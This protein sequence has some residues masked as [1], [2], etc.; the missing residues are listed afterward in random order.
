VRLF[1]ENYAADGVRLPD[2]A[3]DRLR[4]AAQR[5][6][7][8]GLC[9]L[10]CARVG[11]APPLDPMDAVVAAARLA[12]DV[13]RLALPID[14]PAPCAACGACDRVC[15]T[16]VPI[17]R[18]QLDLAARAAAARKPAV[19]SSGAAS[20]EAAPAMAEAPGIG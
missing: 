19:P 8:C 3:G 16:Q 20:P 10:E 2:A 1:L 4:L 11:G 13:V 14:E 5:C 15:P 18:V 7:A 9:T 17:Q 6:V 12:I